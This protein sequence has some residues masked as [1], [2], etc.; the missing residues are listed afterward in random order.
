MDIMDGVDEMGNM[1]ERQKEKSK[2]GG[3]GLQ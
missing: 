2:P 1:D 3:S